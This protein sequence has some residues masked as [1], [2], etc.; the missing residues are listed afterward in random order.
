[1]SK[2]CVKETRARLDIEVFVEC[3]YC[4]ALLDLMRPE[5]TGGVDHNEEGSVLSQ[6]CPDGCWSTEHENFE[7]DDGVKCGSCSKVFAVRGLDW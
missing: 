7:I 1:M 2:E 4:E 5:D 6:A 3:P